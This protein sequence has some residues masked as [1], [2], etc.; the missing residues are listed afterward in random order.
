MSNHIGSHTDINLS[1][2]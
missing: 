2:L 1:L